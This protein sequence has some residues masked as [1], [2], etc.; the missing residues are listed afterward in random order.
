MKPDAILSVF[1]W[2]K[3]ATMSSEQRNERA[4]CQSI[5]YEVLPPTQAISGLSGD[6]SGTR[7]LNKN[8]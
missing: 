8:F 6:H 3:I 1:E 5:P 7:V 2:S 4:A